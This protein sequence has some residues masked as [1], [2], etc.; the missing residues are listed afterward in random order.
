MFPSLCR[1]SVAVEEGRMFHV[2]VFSG[3]SLICIGSSYTPFVQIKCCVAAKQELVRY[4]CLCS[5]C[6][7]RLNFNF[8]SLC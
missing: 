3:D 7:F 1:V 4:P 8:F 6:L 2:S 5:I